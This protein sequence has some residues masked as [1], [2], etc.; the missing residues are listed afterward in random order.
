MDQDQN[1]ESRLKDTLARSASHTDAFE[2]DV[3]ERLTRIEQ[4]LLGKQRQER[5]AVVATA[6]AAEPMEKPSAKS[7]QEALRLWYNG[8]WDQRSS[9]EDKLVQIRHRI[10][11][12]NAGGVIGFLDAARYLGDRSYAEFGADR[13]GRAFVLGCGD[14]EDGKPL[15]A[16]FPYPASDIWFERGVAV[17]ERFYLI[18]GRRDYLAPRVQ[19]TKLALLTG[20]PTGDAGDMVYRPNQIGILKV[21]LGN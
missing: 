14:S 15:F 10:G 7:M 5:N 4:L 1:L 9:L 12:E 16:A 11:A 6:Q 8:L 13:D 3:L 19:V 20:T 18:D 21:E 2:K 17:L